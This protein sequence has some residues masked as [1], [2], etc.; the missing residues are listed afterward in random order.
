MRQY[1]CLFIIAARLFWNAISDLNDNFG[2]LGY[3]IVALFV[4]SWGY[5]S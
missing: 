5:R 2:A 1:G 4:V 3:A